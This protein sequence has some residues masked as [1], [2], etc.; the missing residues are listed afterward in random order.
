MLMLVGVSLH[1]HDHMNDMMMQQMGRHHQAIHT[2][3]YLILLGF[4]IVIILQVL[5]L[6]ALKRK[7]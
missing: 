1:A 5:M 6:Q 2:F 4:V 3:G 7:K